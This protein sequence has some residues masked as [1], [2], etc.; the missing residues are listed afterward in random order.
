MF[1]KFQVVDMQFGYYNYDFEM[2][3]MGGKIVFEVM[4]QVVGDDVVVELDLVWVVCGG[5][6]LVEYLDWFDGCIFVIYVKD[7]VFEGEVVDEKGFK[8]L[9]EGVLDFVRILF[10]VEEVGMKWY[11]IEYD[12]FKDVVVIVK[13]GV[14]FL[15]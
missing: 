12:M 6:D 10:V 2:V 5:F 11:I 9:G 15:I 14:E 7:N 13:I 3:D 4:M 8:V 1:D